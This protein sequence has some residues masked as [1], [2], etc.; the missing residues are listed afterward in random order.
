[1]IAITATRIADRGSI[2]PIGRPTAAVSMRFHFISFHF[3]LEWIHPG[4]IGRPEIT[5][6]GFCILCIFKGPDSKMPDESVNGHNAL[7]EAAKQ[8]MKKITPIESMYD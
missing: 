5:Q 6:T 2:D 3:R 8:T 1:L 4:R 7:K